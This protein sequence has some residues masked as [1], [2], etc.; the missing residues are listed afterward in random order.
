M[1]YTKVVLKCFFWQMSAICCF[2]HLFSRDLSHGI[3]IT[4][5]SRIIL[6]GRAGPDA[7]SERTENREIIMDFMVQE[8]GKDNYYFIVFSD[9]SWIEIPNYSKLSEILTENSKDL[10]DLYL[11]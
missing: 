2:L 3:Y 7:R 9:F 5:R 8:S 1:L 11:I 10:I 4:L 6:A